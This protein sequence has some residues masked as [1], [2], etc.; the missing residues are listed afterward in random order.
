MRLQQIRAVAHPEGN[1]IDLSW[2]NP[3]LG[4]F[5]SVRVVRRVG[6]YPTLDPTGAEP[7]L[8]SAGVIVT[9]L[10]AGSS[11]VNLQ[12]G[13]CTVSDQVPASETVYY[14][15]LYP[16]AG[17][18][19]L[20]SFDSH[21]RT[22][23][24]ATGSYALA[25]RLYEWLPGI[26]YRYDTTLPPATAAV[27]P[28]DRQKGQLRRFLDLPGGQLDQFYSAL[29]AALELHN[30]AQVDG[31]LLPL[32]A[33]W[34]GW[35]TDF[36]LELDAQRNEIR[37][38]PQIYQTIGIVPTVEATVKRIL[39]WESRSKEFVHNVFRTNTPERLNL[40]Q[41]T[42]DANGVW[43][44]PTAPLSLDDAFDGRAAVVNRA[45]G[46][47]DLVYHTL[48]NGVG[49]IR[50]KQRLATGEWQPSMTVA[51]GTAN[52][53]HPTAV[54]QGSTDWIFWNVYARET[55][56]WWIEWRNRP[57]PTNSDAPAPAWSVAASLVFPGDPD[58]VPQRKRPWAIVENGGP[59]GLW[60]FWLEATADGWRV[61]YNRHDGTNWML[62]APVEFP[63]EVG[64][65]DPRVQDDLFVT[66]RPADSSLWLF[67][68]RQQPGGGPGQTRWQIAYRVKANL[69]ADDSGWSDVR[70]L[71]DAPVGSDARE[72]FALVNGA[73][74]L[75]LFWSANT[76]GSWS[77][78]HGVLDGV[79]HTWQTPPVIVTG[80]PYNQRS[81]TALRQGDERHLFY[82]AN[83]SVR[84]T[85]SV[86]GATETLDARYAGATTVH[87]NNVAKSALRG[88]YEDFQTY[89]YD[90]G[91]N[92]RRTQQNWYARDTV[93]MYLTPNT[94]DPVLIE[95]NRN[96][97][98][99]AL[100]K[101]LPIN[102]RTVLI[103]EPSVREEAVYP[104]ARLPTDAF[105]DQL[106]VIADEVLAGVQDAHGDAA[107]DWTWLA[108]WESGSPV[109]RTVDTAADPIDLGDRTRH[110]GIA[111]GQ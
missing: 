56:Q 2:I 25:E 48:R 17:E 13:E 92:G 47:V 49:A 5:P 60:L 41:M 68:A 69:T 91:R 61:R 102:V 86:Y 62:A 3:D 28:A 57:T 21:N 18:P 39:G 12:T 30:V 10:V 98:E 64:D 14:Y 67:W 1:R 35:E 27:A 87:N 52:H 11:A 19:P 31:A 34:I 8:P 93:G 45:D 97:I 59:V 29:R 46:A 109:G 36:R 88:Q 50:R 74:N 101:F 16:F 108:T 104:D 7:L 85:S 105:S 89:T 111:S 71:P 58:P 76:T 43:S 83:E 66:I 40:W 26:Y 20:Y 110:T 95:R 106:T 107:P 55:R 94:E 78:W 44:E 15:T 72:P 77:I 22:A 79:N 54:Q 96:L 9:D 90:T 38:A 53:R 103:I 99:S 80:N 37:N 100:R 75:E 81:P 65:V 32:L 63:P 4:N 42:R 82:R 6:T 24:L 23:A 70:T 73:G 84:Y 33:T 51:Q